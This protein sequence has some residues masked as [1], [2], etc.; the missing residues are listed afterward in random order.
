M[1]AELKDFRGKI[2]TE[3]DC[4]L[5]ALARVSGHDRSEIVRDILH[6]WALEKIHES[7]VL[8]ALLAREGVA[9]ESKGR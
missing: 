6:K 1:S 9:G 4:A 3:T 7:S 2:T 8:A 5:E